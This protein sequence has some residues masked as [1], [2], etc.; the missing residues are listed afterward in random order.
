MNRYRHSEAWSI[1]GSYEWLLS[2]KL[3]SI[4]H[5]ARLIY[6]DLMQTGMRSADARAFMIEMFAGLWERVAANEEAKV[7]GRKAQ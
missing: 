5:L 1:W 3:E 4:D 7:N 6:S 2:E